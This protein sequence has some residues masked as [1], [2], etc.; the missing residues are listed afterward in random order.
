[1]S[2]A[3]NECSFIHPAAVKLLCAVEQSRPG[4]CGAQLVDDARVSAARGPRQR[5]RPGFVISFVDRRAA[6]QKEVDH[7]GQLLR[8]AQPSGVERYSSS[9]AEM[10]APASSRMVAHSTRCPRGRPRPSRPQRSCSGVAR[11]QFGRSGF[12]PPASSSR[13]MS[14]CSSRY[15]R[16]FVTTGGT[17]A[18]ACSSRA[19]RS[20]FPSVAAA[21]N[22]LPHP[23]SAAVGS[24][25][26]RGTTSSSS[27]EPDQ[28][29]AVERAA[30]REQQRPQLRC[31]RGPRGIPGRVDVCVRIGAVIQ[32]QLH[33]RAIAVACGRMKGE[34]SRCVDS[35]QP[36]WDPLH[37]SA[38]SRTISSRPNSTAADSGRFPHGRASRMRVRVLVE[39]P[40]YAVYV[41][42]SGRDG[43]IV[44][45]S[46]FQQHLER[47]RNLPG[48]R[49]KS[50]RSIG[51]K[52]TGA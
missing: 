39:D 36:S 27:F 35:L 50:A 10:L 28:V 30:T 22:V 15:D 40:G 21:A 41:S 37:V 2:W 38:R 3:L 18:P 8:A 14:G 45:G 26:T 24:A 51:W 32:Q 25:V 29:I 31:F 1:M 20:R 12:I 34:A 42:E 48:R 7:V 17:R 4:A 5:R 13:R 11:S 23:T 43:Q 19:T 16:Q 6:S 9:L 52:S 33:H 47:Y 49:Q 44:D 46:Q